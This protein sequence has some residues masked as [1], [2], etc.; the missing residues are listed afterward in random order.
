M[1]KVKKLKVWKEYDI[2]TTV[3]RYT[4]SGMIVIIAKLKTKVMFDSHFNTSTIMI[5]S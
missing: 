1:L 3:F 4:L 5:L 2:G